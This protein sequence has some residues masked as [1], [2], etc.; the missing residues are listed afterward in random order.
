MNGI[1]ANYQRCEALALREQRGAEARYETQAAHYHGFS[2][3]QALCTLHITCSIAM[4][5][6]AVP[7]P[8]QLFYRSFYPD[9]LYCGCL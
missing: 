9:S 2:N 7:L 8:G 3:V 4:P 1:A 6:N 5:G